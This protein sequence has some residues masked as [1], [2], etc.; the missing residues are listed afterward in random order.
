MAANT[1]RLAG[2]TVFIS[3]AS[4]G[5]GKAIALKVAKDGAN[6]VIA[7]KTAQP[8][9][10]LPGTIYTAAEEINKAGGK[11]L[12]CIVDIRSEEQVQ[13]AVQETVA[14][15]GGIDV[16]INNA[17]A[18]SLTGTLKTPMK[19][20]DLMNSINA[21]GTYLCSKVCLPYLLKSKNPHI[22]NISPPLNM[23]AK[24]FQGHV[25]YTMAK[26]GMSM[27]VLG[28][29]EE[30]RD[31][32]VAVNALWPRTAIYTAAMEM[33]GGGSEV[34]EQCRD[35]EIMSDAAY[36]IL[37]KDSSKYTGNFAIDDEVLT[38]AGVTDM[39]KYSC[40]PAGEEAS[41][42]AAVS[43]GLTTMFKALEGLL[44]EDLVK[45]MNSSFQF[46]LSG[47]DSGKYYLDL[48]SGKGVVAPGT[49]EGADCTMVLD[50]GL[51]Q[52]MFAGKA[53]ATTSFMT[54]KLKIKG[55][56]RAAMKLEK[57]MKKMQPK[58]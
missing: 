38:E 39:E 51:F 47:P 4:R 57:L 56:M 25:A 19:T 31:D 34:K 43:S 44:S 53:N 3:G 20:Y 52:D 58:L 42:G 37:S 33:L 48:K 36:V 9:P 23:S 32:R 50:S 54:G 35:V 24:W 17:S 29:A 21:R 1:G 15:F 2:K 11:A 8:H 26:Y 12:P 7:A 14:K 16:L 30:F 5:I 22:L 13:N 10:K 41:A 28:M 55:D 45:E 49:L 18:I 46:D 6:V 27:C 40:V